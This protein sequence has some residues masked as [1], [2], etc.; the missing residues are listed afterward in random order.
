MAK[1]IGIIIHPATHTTVPARSAP[2]AEPNGIAPHMHMSPMMLTI[3]A[4]RPMTFFG[5]GGGDGVTICAPSPDGTV[6]YPREDQHH[7]SDRAEN[8]AD[9]REHE[10]RDAGGACASGAEEKTDR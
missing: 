5:F 6:E 1:A 10:C 7:E 2:A 8:A 4:I 9:D 3:N